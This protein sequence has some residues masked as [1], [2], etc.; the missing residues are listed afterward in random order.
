MS[1][2]DDLKKQ[3]EVAEAHAIGAALSKDEQDEAAL[4]AEINAANE[5]AWAAE[6]QRRGL[7]MAARVDAAREKAAGAYLVGGLDIAALFPLG[8]A[9][10]DLPGDGV[11]VIR[12]AAPAEGG[13]LADLEHKNAADSKPLVKSLLE[14]ACKSLVD[15]D[16]NGPDGALFRCFCERYP[17]AANQIA[18]EARRLG[19][20]K[21][22]EAKR[23]SE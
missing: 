23:G 11:I 20:A 21:V 15:P 5:A 12:D 22:R 2:I 17:A 14:V 3:L 7:A 8:K 13:L 1:K 9:P 6:A 10:A 18:G 4:R 16:P 19:G